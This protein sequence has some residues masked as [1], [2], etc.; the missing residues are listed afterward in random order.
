LFALV[1]PVGGWVQPP[2]GAGLAE[3]PESKRRAVSL[4]QVSGLV[5]KVDFRSAPAA[6]DE[7][8]R[9]IHAPAYLDDFRRLSAAGGGEL[10]PYAPFGPGSFDIAC[11]SAGLA[12]HAVES[13][14]S[15]S[16]RNAYAMSRPPGHHCLAAQPMGFC[17]LNNIAIAVERARARHGVERVVVLTGTCTMV[18]ERNPFSTRATTYSASQYIKRAV[19]RP[20]IAAHRT[21]EKVRASVTT[22]ICP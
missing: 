18:T 16:Y 1:T 3:S 7:D 19:F 17:L 14:L 21:V 6:E 4:L 20:A 8:L 13:V 9:C 10:G 22:L 12:Q 11:V 15:G 5:D 2:A